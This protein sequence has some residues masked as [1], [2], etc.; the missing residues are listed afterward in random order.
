MP[1]LDWLS[2][3]PFTIGLVYLFYDVNPPE[4]FNLRRDVYMRLAIFAHHRC[5]HPTI[6]NSATLSLCYLH[7]PTYFTG[8]TIKHRNTFH[9]DC[10]LISQ[11]DTFCSCDGNARHIQRI[12]E[13]IIDESLYFTTF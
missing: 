3:M 8:V 11:F 6:L 1:M 12:S 13:I 7:G 2:G 10:I 9:G 4:G 5:K